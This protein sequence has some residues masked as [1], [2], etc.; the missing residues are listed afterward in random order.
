MEAVSH[1]FRWGDIVFRIRPEML[2][3]QSHQPKWLK[4]HLPIA[5]GH[6][7]LRFWILDMSGM[8]ISV[9]VN[10]GVPDQ[11]QIT[12]GFYAW[13]TGGFPLPVV[14]NHHLMRSREASYLRGLATHMWQLFYYVQ[15]YKRCSK[16][17]LW[18][19]WSSNSESKTLSDHGIKASFIS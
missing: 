7:L 11:K 10:S 14:G 2:P 3:K 16:K 15:T 6:L 5:L 9:C 18:S 1:G 4:L 17:V 13:E 19:D 12:P 8:E